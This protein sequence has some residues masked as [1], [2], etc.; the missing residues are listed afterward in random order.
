MSAEEAMPWNGQSLARP[1]ESFSNVACQ[2][3]SPVASR[4]AIT[5]PRSPGCLGSRTASLLVP[6][7]TTPPA[8]VGLPYD[9]EPRSATHLMFLPVLTSHVVG[10]PFMGDTMLRAGVPPHIGQSADKTTVPVS[11]S[12]E[13]RTAICFI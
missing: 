12:T 11:A 9:C 4:N 6:M 1:D 5:T 7:R 3:N 13:M 8:T 2:R 10:R